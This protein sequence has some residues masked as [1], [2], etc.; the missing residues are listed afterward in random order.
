MLTAAIRALRRR[1]VRPPMTRF[2]YDRAGRVAD[3][4][5]L[6][7]RAVLVTGAGRNI[8]RSIALEMAGQGASVYFTDIDA[9]SIASLQD[10]LAA[11][12]A[13]SRGFRSDIA[14]PGEVARLCEALVAEGVVIDVLV[15]NVGH[16]P[17]VGGLRALEMAAVRSTFEVNVFGPLDLTRRIVDGMIAAGRPGT[18]L[19]VTS[20]H[21]RATVGSVAYS[22]S[23]AAL[24]MIIKELAF[25]LAPHRIRV[26]GIA[27][28]SVAVADGD[29]LPAF[30]AS[31]LFGTSIHPTYI[32]RAAVYL[33]SDY[34]SQFSTGTVLTIDAGMLARPPYL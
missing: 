8:G 31:P 32:G 7:G 17:E 9:P 18:V 33:A 25:E 29:E 28:G 22:A 14:M 15:N 26:N 30:P 13:R 19:F 20:V 6:E 34:F 3:Q 12:G 27:P 11:A 10:E 1:I 5:L 24:T 16:H 4:R 21:D 2:V 23:K